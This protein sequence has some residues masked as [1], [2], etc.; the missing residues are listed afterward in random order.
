M[1]FLNPLFL[2]GLLAASIP[3]LIHLLNVR[4]L[5]RI[6]FSTLYFLKELQKNK[7]RRIK[8]K[9]LLL[10]M[11]RVLLVLFLVLAFSRPTLDT[12]TISGLGSSV[13]SSVVLI[14]DNSPSTEA[15]TG[16]GSVFNRI[17]SDAKLILNAIEQG[18][19][20]AIIFSSG[21]ENYSPSFTSNSYELH[22]LIDNAT[23][24]SNP[25]SHSELTG[26]AFSLLKSSSNYKKD[27]IYFSDFQQSWGSIV[28]SGEIAENS[29]R[30]SF[31]P[32][33]YSPT[34]SGNIAIDTLY[35]DTRIF[36][37]GGE[38]AVSVKLTNESEVAGS[39][40]LSLLVNGKRLAQKG[41]NVPAGE[42]TN[43]SLV[44]TLRESGI[45]QVAVALED[46]V[47]KFDNS[48]F[49]TL[50]VPAQQSFLILENS[51]GDAKFVELALRAASQSTNLIITTRPL[52]QVSEPLLK[53]Y[54]AVI[55]AGVKQGSNLTGLRSYVE[56]GKGLI[57]FPAANTLQPDINY[58]LAALGLPQSTGIFSPAAGQESTLGIVDAKH[59]IVE[60]LY[61]GSALPSQKKSIGTASINNAIKLNSGGMG[62]PILVF[63][64][65]SPM[66]MEYSSGQGK[67]FVFSSA[68]AIESGDL[69]FKNYFAP[70]LYTTALYASMGSE[71][72]HYDISTE[73]VIIDAQLFSSGTVKLIRPSFDFETITL[74][75]YA[76]SG[77][78]AMNINEQ[79]FYSVE[80]TGVVKQI[81][82]VNTP[83]SEKRYSQLSK[84]SLAVFQ[85]SFG[86]SGTVV[87][88]D[89][90]IVE[91]VSGKR[92]G[93]ELWRVFII[94][95][96]LV[97]IIEL[98]VARATKKDLVD[99]K[100]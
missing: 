27:I 1:T 77:F 58:L 22:S 42:S 38:I 40:V 51:P 19:E 74:N 96:L 32:I 17:K 20:A 90:R 60:A 8:I 46:D 52:A 18:D 93:T 81:F 70:L 86:F 80:E 4:K 11:L 24:A 9:Q 25:K 48:A 98:I 5:K 41:I 6:E 94:A 59:A 82:G 65:G 88:G 100:N 12:V 95:A 2:F 37:V 72:T 33:V 62:K 64:D 56:A 3:I 67:V 26:Q 7:V 47:I 87:N 35:F 83:L 69:V 97:G 10:L 23:I 66:F 49:A 39:N 57:V 79:G 21:Y 84:D 76:N 61:S 16:K 14:I 44:A 92:F 31:F 68:A 34:V 91:Y 55:I 29:T 99:L 43:E 30:T 78:R 89:E 54:S 13:K 63:A 71:N 85:N 73:G 75:N 28:N 15:G 45:I 53:E 36:R 50:T